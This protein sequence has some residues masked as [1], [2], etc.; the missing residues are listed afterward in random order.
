MR[1]NIQ[2]F[3]MLNYLADSL[4]KKILD[5]PSYID[6]YIEIVELMFTRNKKM[7]I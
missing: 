2:N 1:S 3:Y 7:D 5:E 6:K 4:F